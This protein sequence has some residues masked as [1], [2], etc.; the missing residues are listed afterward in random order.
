MIPTDSLANATED[1]PRIG[2]LPVEPRAYQPGIGLIG[3]GNISG[4]HL[5]AYATAGYRILALCDLDIDRAEARRAEFFP[6]AETMTEYRELLRRPDID[7]VDIATHVDVRPHLVGEALRSGKHVLSQKPFVRDLDEGEQLIALAA[8][9]GKTVAVNQNGRW[10]PHFAYLLAAARQGVLGSISTADFTVYWPHDLGVQAHPVFSQMEDLILYDF[11]I[12]WFDMIAQ[13]FAEHG[14]AHS[15]YASVS[16]RS[17]QVIP[18]PTQAQVVI[19]YENASATV[20]L[21]GSSR[22]VESGS[23]RVDGS[24]G[25]LTHQG[26]SLGG[27]EVRLVTS[28]IDRVETL[29]GDWWKNGMHGAMS[30]LICAIEEGRPPSNRASA[31]LP[32]LTLCFA[33]IASSRTGLPVDPRTARTLPG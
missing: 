9:Q 18:V 32:G 3:C 25:M 27:H 1:R 19:S 11:G 8:E 26:L 22:L 4:K 17:D 2:Y 33:A 14:Q 7:I 31:S 28:D 24:A 21:R 29:T 5:A 13:L 16:R 6:A 23:Y 20:V 30:E 10:A 15:V 12:H